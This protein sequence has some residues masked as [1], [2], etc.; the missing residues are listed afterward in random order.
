M[1][2]KVAMQVTSSLSSETGEHATQQLRW[3]SLPR[4]QQLQYLDEALAP[5][6]TTSLVFDRNEA[7]ALEEGKL[8]SFDDRRDVLSGIRTSVFSTDANS[9][10]V[11]DQLVAL[12]G[13]FKKKST[14]RKNNMGHI[15]APHLRSFIMERWVKKE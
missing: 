6:S 10:N 11:A 4:T 5:R 3:S 1:I 8:V 15:Y 2:M 14:L 9:T 12:T 13:I 7:L